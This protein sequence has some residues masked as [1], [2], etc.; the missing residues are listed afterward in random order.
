MSTKKMR[1]HELGAAVL[2]L[3]A[4]YE[5]PAMHRVQGRATIYYPRDGHC[6]THRADG[7]PFTKTDDH[8]AHRTLPLGTRGILCSLRTRRCTLTAV[9]DRGPYGAIRS[10][11]GA[12]PLKPAKL[13]RWS[14]TCFWWQA[15]VRLQSGWRRRGEF[16]LTRPV[17]KAIGHRPFD[18]VIFFYQRPAQPES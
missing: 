5:D 15:Q 4:L 12:P 2:S 7:K 10:C 17:A 6:G 9:R 16:D 8:V 14:K 3:A 18:K 1:F 11:R 13:A